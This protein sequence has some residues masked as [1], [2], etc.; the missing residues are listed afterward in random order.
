MK[1]KQNKAT[2]SK[3]GAK[4]QQGKN[5][6][7]GSN[8]NNLMILAEKAAQKGG[9]NSAIEMLKSKALNGEPDAVYFL[10]KLYLCEDVVKGEFETGWHLLMWCAAHGVINAIVDVA[11]IALRSI[12]SSKDEKAAFS[13]IHEAASLGHP[14]CESILSFFYKVGFGCKR[15]MKMAHMWM[16]KAQIDN[17]NP[18]QA[19]QILGVDEKDNSK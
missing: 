1:K 14:E 7:V 9:I 5:G 18:E 19:L 3:I 11:A 6:V 10:S 8:S 15:N 2:A 13:W 16:L 17:Y 12:E 4:A